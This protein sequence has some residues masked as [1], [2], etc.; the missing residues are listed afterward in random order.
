MLLKS[1]LQL[2]VKLKQL[3]SAVSRP[4]IFSNHRR[5]QALSNAQTWLA[6]I[7]MLNQR[8][9]HVSELWSLF[10][11]LTCSQSV[12]NWFYSVLS[13]GTCILCNRY[14]WHFL[15]FINFYSVLAVSNLSNILKCILLLPSDCVYVRYCNAIISIINKNNSPVKGANRPLRGG[16]N[17]LVA[18]RLGG[19]PSRWRNV[20]GA[21]RPDGETSKR[22]NVQGAKRLGAKRP[23]GELTKG[24]N[25]QL[26]NT[27]VG[28]SG[29]NSPPNPNPNP[30]HVLLDVYKVNYSRSAHW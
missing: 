25:V 15:T 10:R 26:P 21:N 5:K 19:E 7:S 23:G 24:R 29:N 30:K 14:A 11:I 2:N 3:S 1:F 17:V 20:Q 27:L 9:R 6:V 18:K 16:E 22:R 12:F 28:H 8:R 13:S 4:R